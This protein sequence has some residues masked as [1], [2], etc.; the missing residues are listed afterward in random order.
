MI[1]HKY[2]LIN[3]AHRTGK[4]SNLPAVQAGLLAQDMGLIF[5]QAILV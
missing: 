3:Y 5:K 2:N 1:S 4:T